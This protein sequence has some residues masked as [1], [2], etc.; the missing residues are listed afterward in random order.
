MQPKTCQICGKRPSRY[1]CQ[2]CGREVCQICLEP[3]TWVCLPC[4][5]KIRQKTPPSPR[6]IASV[7]FLP[8]PFKLFLLGFLLIFIG[9]ILVMIASVAGGVSA[10]ALIW[11]LPFPPIFL[12]A[13]QHPY[14]VWA[15]ILATI[16][17]ILGVAF[18]IILRKQARRL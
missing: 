8:L 5:E 18:F 2:E 3:H 16:L 17:T 15:I 11:I 1:V 10:G 12:G 14:T 7:S 6:E 9:I 4:Y 13:G